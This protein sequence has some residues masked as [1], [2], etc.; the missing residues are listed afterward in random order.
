MIVNAR[1]VPGN[2]V[3]TDALAHARKCDMEAKHSG[4]DE[5][6]TV[7]EAES[8]HLRRLSG[9]MAQT[10]SDCR[11]YRDDL[12]RWRPGEVLCACGRW[13]ERWT[14]GNAEDVG[15]F[16]VRRKACECGEMLVIANNPRG[17][18]LAGIDLY[19]S[20]GK[21]SDNSINSNRISG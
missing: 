5:S 10:V 4:S 17:D 12:D 13:H 15:G 9:A 7:V 21:N 6:L 8:V 20:V 14:F 18:V 1:S 11:R 2:P 19:Q 3:V 16:K